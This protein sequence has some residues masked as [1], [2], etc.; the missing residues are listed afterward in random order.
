MFYPENMSFEER[1]QF[2]QTGIALG[3]NRKRFEILRHYTTKKGFA[4]LMFAHWKNTGELSP[5]N[6]VS[7]G[8]PARRPKKKDRLKRAK[9]MA[10]KT[11]GVNEEDVDVHLDYIRA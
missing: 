2:I 6:P 4:I 1:D 8:R 9:A 10:S 11:L 7:K 3:W 5:K